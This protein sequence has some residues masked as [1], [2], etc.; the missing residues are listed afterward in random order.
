MTNDDNPYAA[1]AAPTLLAPGRLERLRGLRPAEKGRRF[2]NY[3]VD[4]VATTIVSEA[5]DYLG[6]S[7]FQEAWQDDV[8]F[9]LLSFAINLLIS[10]LYFFAFETLTGRTLGKYLTGTCVVDPLGRRP[11]RKTIALRSLCRLIPFEVLSFLASDVG[12]HDSLSGTRVV[13][14]RELEAKLEKARARSEQAG[15]RPATG[16]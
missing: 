2:V 9:S 7:L 15:E 8:L 1:P 11:S 3:L 5:L 16:D 12:W 14:I 10:F 4:L 13:R 6:A